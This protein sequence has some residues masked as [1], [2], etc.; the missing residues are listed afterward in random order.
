M[1]DLIPFKVSENN[2]LTSEEF[3]N[4]FFENYFIKKSF[5]LKLINEDFKVK[6]EET[7]K[8]YF[9]EADLRNF[10]K[11]DIKVEYVNKFLVISAENNTK[12][13][14]KNYVKQR[15]PSDNFRRMFYL[16]NIHEKSIYTNYNN[17]FL[18][19]V[20]SKI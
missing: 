12:G 6:L 1:N 5:N 8:K 17:G 7:P 15:I 16:D 19:I 13:K 14:S 10:N 20:L 2:F 18:T 3:F 4:E 11:K 9:V